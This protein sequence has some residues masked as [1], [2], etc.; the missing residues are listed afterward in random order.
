MEHTC[1]NCGER[2]E[3]NE[4]D[5]ICPACGVEDVPLAQGLVRG[6]LY[7]LAAAVAGALVWFG[8]VLALDS[9]K[10]ALL[11]AALI[12]YGVPAVMAIGSMRKPRVVIPLVSLVLVAA[13]MA[14]GTYWLF[15]AWA[16]KSMDISH[17]PW[18]PS[19]DYMVRVLARGAKGDIFVPMTWGFAFIGWVL[20]PIQIWTGKGV[21]GWLG[22][23][24]GRMR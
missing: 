15:R 16:G 19:L 10:I 22:R 5:R 13:S 2:Y 23:S 18:M 6:G 24:L 14:F 21:S 20:L 1:S 11:L 4:A 9:M 8:L 12:G 7:G 17:V 3:G